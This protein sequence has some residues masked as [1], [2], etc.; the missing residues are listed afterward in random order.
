MDVMARLNTEIAAVPPQVPWAGSRA[1][2]RSSFEGR[3]VIRA[4][5]LAV[6]HDGVFRPSATHKEVHSLGLIPSAELV[7]LSV[8]DEG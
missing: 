7:V 1:F 6:D 3:R 2:V 4:V 5:A 8:R